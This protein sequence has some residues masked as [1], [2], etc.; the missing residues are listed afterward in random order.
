MKRW[1]W[2]RLCNVEDFFFWCYEQMD[3]L[4]SWYLKNLLR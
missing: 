2:N 3:R 4:T 1:I